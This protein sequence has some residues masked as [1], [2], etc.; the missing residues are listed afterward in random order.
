MKL[1]PPC[2]ECGKPAVDD[3]GLDDD[4]E[5]GEYGEDVP[6]ILVCIDDHEWLSDI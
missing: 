3:L 2:P 6:H 1:G 5:Y 4:G